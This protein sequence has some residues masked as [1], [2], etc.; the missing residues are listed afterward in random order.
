MVL[1]TMGQAR[2]ITAIRRPLRSSIVQGVGNRDPSP[3]SWMLA[4][5]IGWRSF[6]P[7]SLTRAGP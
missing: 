3:S 6:A 5:S 1:S 7:S 2:P 4:A